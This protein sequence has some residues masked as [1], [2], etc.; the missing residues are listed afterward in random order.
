MIF[1][2]VTALALRLVR[3][4]RRAGTPPCIVSSTCQSE[5]KRTLRLADRCGRSPHLRVVLRDASRSFTADGEREVS[6]R[7][8]EM[9]AGVTFTIFTPTRRQSKI[10][11]K[12]N[13]LD[14][15]QIFDDLNSMQI[16]AVY[17]RLLRKVGL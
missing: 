16:L 14:F 13:Q 6:E 8:F 5:I 9:V 10:Y 3:L 17:Q 11:A 15:S 7:G 12:S 2:T 1:K 4:N